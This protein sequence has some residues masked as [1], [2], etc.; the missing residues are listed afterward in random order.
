MISTVQKNATEEAVIR[1]IIDGL[2]LP[3]TVKEYR[4]RLTNDSFG[5]PAVYLLFLLSDD[6]KPEEFLSETGRIQRILTDAILDSPETERWPFPAFS[7]VE[8]QRELER[9]YPGTTW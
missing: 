7:S 4:L 6:L 1:R 3:D 8:E 9:K 5:D 2:D